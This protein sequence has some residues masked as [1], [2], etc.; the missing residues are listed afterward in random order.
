[1]KYRGSFTC[2][3]SL[4][5]VDV[6]IWKRSGNEKAAFPKT[7]DFSAYKSLLVGGIPTRLKNMKVSWDD[8]FQYM[9]NHNPAMFQTIPNHQ[10][11]LSS[12]TNTGS[13]SPKYL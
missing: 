6:R 9:E 7:R 12:Q 8:Y 10:P 2:S 13:I 3:K 11:A 4:A 5:F 1:V